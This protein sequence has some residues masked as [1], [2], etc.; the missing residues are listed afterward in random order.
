MKIRGQQGGPGSLRGLLAWAPGT[1]RPAT[2]SPQC[3]VAAG[4]LGSLQPGG[5]ARWPVAGAG[6]LASPGPLLPAYLYIPSFLFISDTCCEPSDLTS[7]RSHPLPH[8]AHPGPTLQPHPVCVTSEMMGAPAVFTARCPH[9]LGNGEV[10]P[11]WVAAHGSSRH[12]LG[13]PS[14]S[15]T[16]RGSSCHLLA[17]SPSGA[18]EYVAA[19]G[20][21]AP[22]APGRGRTGHTEYSPGR[23]KDCM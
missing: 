20:R 21:V 6:W 13:G 1:S 19:G 10:S 22:R 2:Q 9:L 23:P 11:S 15:A 7:S 4:S 17:R 14:C 5:G 3:Q 18:P 12:S 16:C 8:R